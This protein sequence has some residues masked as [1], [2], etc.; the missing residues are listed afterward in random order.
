MFCRLP[1]MNAV[2]TKV[3]DKK[4]SLKMTDKFNTKS[5]LTAIADYADEGTTLD[6]IQDNAL[7][8]N[9]WIIGT[10][11]AAKALEQF[12]EN[13]QLYLKT[14]LNGVFGAIQYVDDYET[15]EI[16]QV[17][18]DLFD[19]EAVASA[20]ASINGEQIISKLAEELNLDFDDKL[21]K[22]QAE[23]LSNVKA[24]QTLLND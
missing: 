13:D 22:Q 6:S 9:P 24:M 15:N 21:T 1:L 11:K 3:K 23:R 10:Y 19:P 18:T 8:M 4:E 17:Y 16:G 2:G 5:I 7:N 14:N 20:V 12:S